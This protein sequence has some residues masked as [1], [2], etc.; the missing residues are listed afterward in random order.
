VT[1]TN[2]RGEFN[3]VH[4][5]VGDYVVIAAKSTA[6]VSAGVAAVLLTTPEIDIGLLVNRITD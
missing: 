6:P 4:V 2:E 3:F 5:P 1:I